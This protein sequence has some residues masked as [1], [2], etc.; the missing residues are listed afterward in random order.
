MRR[1]TDWIIGHLPPHTTFV[2]PFFGSGAVFFNKPASKSEYINDLDGD[3]CNLF[4]VM[5]EQPERLA[6]LI[7]FTPYSRDEYEL[8][9]EPTADPVE[10]ARR[11][12]VKHWLSIGGN[13]GGRYITGWRHSGAKSAR[14]KS[15]VMEWDRLPERI[16]AHARRLKGAHIE[17]RPA[18][19]LLGRLNHPTVLAYVDPPYHPD[20]R[21]GRMYNEEMLLE[22]QHVE[23]L[24]FLAND[25]QGMCVL[26]GY[27]H[28][29]YDDLL[30]GW[31]RI[32]RAAGA[33]MGQ[34]RTEVLWLNPAAEKRGL[35]GGGA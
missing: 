5:R 14:S 20:T 22:A 34:T 7:D 21:K 9:Y 4:R 27:P 24:E 16:L 19:E 2:E 15:C 29:L 10:R 1:P 18:L 31:A 17:N 12:L 32:E 6:G 25:W 35:F 33:E 8:A 3:I 30:T 26:S 13:G 28:P 23:L 11:T